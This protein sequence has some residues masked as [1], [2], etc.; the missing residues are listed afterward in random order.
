M[1]PHFQT[2]CD[3]ILNEAL[4]VPRKAFAEV[5]QYVADSYKRKVFGDVER[6][7]LKQFPPKEF[8]LDFTGT[9]YQHL[10]VIKPKVV[11]SFK[12]SGQSF[13]ME[14]DPNKINPYTMKDGVGYIV[15]SFS[16]RLQSILSEVA[17]HEMFHYLQYAAVTY[18]IK[19]NQI[20]NITLNQYS[21]YLGGLP[22]K[23]VIPTDVSISGLKMG[24]NKKWTVALGPL[25]NNQILYANKRPIVIPAKTQ[26]EAWALFQKKFPSAITQYPQG[27]LSMKDMSGKYLKG[28]KRVEHTSRPVEYYT[29]LLSIIRVMQFE[30][31]DKF[32]DMKKEQ[33]FMLFTKDTLSDRLRQISNIIYAHDLFQ[34]FKDNTKKK[35]VAGGKSLYKTVLHKMYSGFINDDT[36]GTVAEIKQVVN[37]FHEDI[38]NWRTKAKAEQEEPKELGVTEKD[39][40]ATSMRFMRLEDWLVDLDD[41]NTDTT[42][43][44][45]QDLGIKERV[46]DAGDSYYPV[47]M[48]Y[49]IVKNYFKKFKKLIQNA[50]TNPDPRYMRDEK[51]LS[52]KDVYIMAS[53]LLFNEIQQH[54]IRYSET[55]KKIPDELYDLWIS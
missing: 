8:N 17:E 50:S 37:K 19:T 32:H 20:P 30:Y 35:I 11:I 28:S 6:V 21:K 22:S 55:S 5:L 48:A 12:A 36:A 53:R 23:Q 42:E 24:E 13:F 45:F 31:N 54:L 43:S 39:F 4:G 29:D 27:S 26:E 7:T 18:K 51:A 33:F 14:V 9:N 16:E 40:H 1:Q 44:I 38:T 41:N 10:N 2:I 52:E 25:I 49:T 15:F 46:P 47:A 34:S 3:A